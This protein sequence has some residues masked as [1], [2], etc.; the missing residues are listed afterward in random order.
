MIRQGVNLYFKIMV[1]KF[2]VCVACLRVHVL[3]DHLCS[4]HWLYLDGVIEGR[5]QCMVGGG[6]IV[7]MYGFA[8]HFTMQKVGS[9]TGVQFSHGTNFLTHIITLVAKFL[10]D[11]HCVSHVYINSLRSGGHMLATP[12]L[13]IATY[14]PQ[15][16]C[17]G[18]YAYIVWRLLAFAIL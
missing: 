8:S 17:V 13:K 2:E 10:C 3:R 4:V 12:H 9:K 18:R 11:L 1:S 5:C 15:K 16:L 14:V 6:W 7:L